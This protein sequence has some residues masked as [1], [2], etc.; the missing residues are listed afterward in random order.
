MDDLSPNAQLLQNLSNDEIYKINQLTCDE[1]EQAR[2]EIDF[3]TPKSNWSLVKNKKRK[4]RSAESN[5]ITQESKRT[6]ISINKPISTNKPNSPKLTAVIDGVSK[7][8]NTID[9]VK[10]EIINFKPNINISEIKLL[11]R[12]GILLTLSDVANFNSIIKDWPREIF[13]GNSYITINNDLRDTLSINK[14]AIEDDPNDIIDAL[15][16]SNIEFDCFRRHYNQRGQP[17]TLICFKVN[18]KI[19]T[20]NLLQNGII[21]NNEKKIIRKF[22]D[23]DKLVS[24]CTKCQK[25]GHIYTKCLAKQYTCARC[26]GNNCPKICQKEIKK[27]ANCNGDHSA[28]YKGCSMYK[29]AL[30]NSEQLYNL[31]NYTKN[32]NETEKQL[33]TSYADMVK[34]SEHT[35]KLER[36]KMDN[37]YSKLKSAETFM[38]SC[39]DIVKK[40]EVESSEEKNKIIKL[41]KKITELERNIINKVD[42]AVIL[43]D[44]IARCLGGK[45]VKNNEILQNV[46][47][48]VGS[49]FKIQ[50]NHNSII[51]GIK[52][53]I[54][55]SLASKIKKNSNLKNDA[56]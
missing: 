22:I 28:A 46:V 49:Y 8:F 1:I 25:F 2:F 43:T 21:L 10:N 56:P 39:E 45:E 12:G 32:L 23:K 52:Q 29:T 13:G 47:H 14:F 26:G 41:E 48:V 27:C 7:T 6:A 9:L 54:P 36:E 33:K 51:N 50:I 42:L 35:L 44:C 19:S 53:H 15:N 5:K 40:V 24:R 17:T 20:E 11:K 38:N 3:A 37:L 31:Q 34:K 18:N 4:E 30:R 55:S 16:K